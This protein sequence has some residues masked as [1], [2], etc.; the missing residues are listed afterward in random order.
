MIKLKA[1]RRS[2]GT[3]GHIKQLRREGG[4]P[5]VLYSPKGVSD[6]LLIESK[7]LS[8]SMRGIKSGSL[9]TTRF[10]LEIDG[11]TQLAIVKEIQYQ[12]TTYQI[13]HI[14][15]E[16]LE[17]NC[18][19]I[20][21]VPIQ[22]HGVADCVGIKLG[23]FLRQVI[24]SV[25]VKSLPK[26]IPSEFIIDIKD[27]GIGGAKRIKDIMIPEGVQPLAKMD[28]VALLISKRAS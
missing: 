9:A 21:K 28:E 8:L 13:I 20:V 11:V 19:V 27:L 10:A 1:D 4:V 5:A 17:E 2:R 16:A 26:D 23:G 7:S 24:R 12:P 6:L 18:P 22:C 15:F 25:Q 3:K 14:D